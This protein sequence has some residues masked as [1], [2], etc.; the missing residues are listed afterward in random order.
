MEI[1]LSTCR[2]LMVSLLLGAVQVPAQLK[3]VRDSS[4]QPTPIDQP[5]EDGTAEEFRVEF[6]FDDEAGL[7]GLPLILTGHVPVAAHLQRRID[8]FAISKRGGT[9]VARRASATI[10]LLRTLSLAIGTSSTHRGSN[11]LLALACDLIKVPS[12]NSQCRIRTMNKLARIPLY[13]GL[14]ASL[15]A[16]TPIIGLLHAGM[17]RDRSRVFQ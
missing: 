8:R 4:S 17:K 3:T 11:V 7:A 10:S 9:H 14:L 2:L 16:P 15:H 13:M 5:I 6:E 1:L 12:S